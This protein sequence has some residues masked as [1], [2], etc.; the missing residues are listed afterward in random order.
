MTVKEIIHELKKH[1]SKKNC[2]GMARFGINTEKA[3]G[4][5]IPVIR[6]I[7]KKIGKNHNLALKLWDTEYHEARILASMID[8]PELVTKSQMDKW[9]K[10]FNS[11]DLCDQT[12]MNLFCR[13]QF[14]NEKIFKWSKSKNEF[15]KR[16]AFTLIACLA[17]YEK[18]LE[19]SE[20]I[21]YFDLIRTHSTDER[22][23]VKKAVNWS[24]RQIGKRNQTLREEALKLSQEILML[25][26]KSAKWIAKDAIR[27]LNNF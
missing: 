10:D 3:F 23:F 6:R 16:A 22:N 11:W 7:A 25:N 17:V 20:F 14:A 9:A 26:S 5:N 21:K 1:G 13:T 18:N 15:V 19:D 2:E 27:E 12:C 8:K 4:V 24:L